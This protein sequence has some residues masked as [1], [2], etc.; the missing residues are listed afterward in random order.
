MLTHL[1]Y[2]VVQ[3]R[4]IPVFFPLCILWNQ[5]R[6][7]L[8]GQVVQSSEA[9]S[10]TQLASVPEPVACLAY[11]P[12]M[13][14]CITFVISLCQSHRDICYGIIYNCQ[15]KDNKEGAGDM[16]LRSL[17]ALPEDPQGCSQPESVTPVPGNP[18]P[19]SGL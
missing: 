13:S 9:G 10:A 19:S 17:A 11:P 18:A 1:V 14:D 5:G 8:T 15:I 16:A 2:T 12:L 4:L 6:E 3:K 7:K